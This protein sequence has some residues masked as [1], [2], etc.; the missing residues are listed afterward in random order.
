MA[1]LAIP[2]IALGGMYIMSNQNQNKKLINREAYTNMTPER[3]ELP[4]V[5]P[6]T[7]A[8]NYP[9]TAPVNQSN[10]KYYPN[11][12]Q[13]TDKYYQ[14]DVYKLWCRRH[15]STKLSIHVRRS[16]K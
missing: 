6:P 11:P 10:V 14:K 7:P 13:T 9:I 2:L 16:S 15:I 3:N 5:N 12:N 4:N 8:I 1:E